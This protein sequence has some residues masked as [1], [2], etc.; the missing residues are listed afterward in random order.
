[1]SFLITSDFNPD[2]EDDEDDDSA[3]GADTINRLVLDDV[4][5]LDPVDVVRTGRDTNSNF[6]FVERLPVFLPVLPV[7]DVA[8]PPAVFF[9]DISIKSS[10]SVS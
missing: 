9:I 6:P 1:V 4:D 2:D 5:E 7:P 8:F 3:G 10:S